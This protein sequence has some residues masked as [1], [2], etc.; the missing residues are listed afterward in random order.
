MINK[1]VAVILLL[2]AF[3][4]NS[5]PYDLNERA[6]DGMDVHLSTEANALEGFA[7]LGQTTFLLFGQAAPWG[8]DLKGTNC[9]S[10]YMNELL[11]SYIPLLK[12]YINL[13]TIKFQSTFFSVILSSF[14]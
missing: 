4:L 7:G 9:Y 11:Y 3:V 8:H 13:L 10:Q 14:K 1:L 12:T 5:Y 2:L 6:L